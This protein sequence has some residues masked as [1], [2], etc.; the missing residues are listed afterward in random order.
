M[1]IAFIQ[2]NIFIT[3]SE[4]ACLAD[5]GL[6]TVRDTQVSVAT[7]VHGIYGTAGYMAPELISV[8]EDPNGATLLA[9]LDRRRCDM[10]AFGCITYE[11]N[12]HPGC[13]RRGL[14]CRVLA[15]VY[16]RATLPREQ[17]NC[18]QPGAAEWSQAATSHGS[19]GPRAR[20]GRR[21]VAVYREPLGTSSRSPP[22]S[23]VGA[24]F[25]EVQGVGHGT[26]H[27]SSAGRPRVGYWILELSR[28]GEG[29]LYV[30]TISIQVR[31][32]VL[33]HLQKKEL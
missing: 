24:G 12:D 32:T 13:K 29:H 31:L 2:L 10:F 7:T 33:Y 11:V 18:A 28:C 27:V 1:L 19:A 14:T 22:C 17:P 21:H 25:L 15:G 23:G 9:Q 26:E 8:W 30:V 4:R 20:A 5:F 16:R 6:A 3:A